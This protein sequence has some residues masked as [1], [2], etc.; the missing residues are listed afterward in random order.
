MK[1]LFTLALLMPVLMAA[2]AHAA[3]NADAYYGINDLVQQ[4][5]RLGSKDLR[6]AIAGIINVVLGFLG[7]VAVIIVLLGGF[8]WMTSQGSSDKTDEAKKLIGAGVVGLAIV[9][10]AYAVASFVLGELYN[11]TR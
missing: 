5:V 7:V 9:L 8:K 6:T 3:D 11:A 1:K 4:G 10:A 2:P